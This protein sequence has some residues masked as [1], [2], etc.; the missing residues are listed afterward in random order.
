MEDGLFQNYDRPSEYADSQRLALDP[1][2]RNFV[3]EFGKNEA[4]IAFN[5]DVDKLKHLLK[6][7]RSPARPVRWMYAS[8]F[9]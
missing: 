2:S 1:A 4:Q 3:V 7:K 8:F 6:T 5:L 9:F